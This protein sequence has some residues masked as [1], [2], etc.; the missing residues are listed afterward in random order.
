MI[1]L[2]QLLEKDENLWLFV[3]YSYI[4]Y[5]TKKYQLFDEEL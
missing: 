2:S 3:I 4:D 5:N 1:L